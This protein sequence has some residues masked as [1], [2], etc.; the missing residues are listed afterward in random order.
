MDVFR[1]IRTSFTV[2]GIHPVLIP[3]FFKHFNIKNVIVLLFLGQYAISTAVYFLNEAR[4][5]SEFAESFYIFATAALV[6]VAF[7]VI[8]QESSN[9]FQLIGEFESVIHESKFS[10]V[11]T[12]LFLILIGWV[13]LFQD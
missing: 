13:S 9:I 3:S 12:K 7:L 4:T 11:Q 5:L 10:S 1:S 2:L 8:I 6:F